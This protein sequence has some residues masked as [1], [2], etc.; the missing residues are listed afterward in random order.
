MNERRSQRKRERGTIVSIIEMPRCIPL[1][2]GGGGERTALTVVK[3]FRAAGVTVDVNM[4][5]GNGRARQTL[6]RKEGRKED[7]HDTI[8]GS[9]RGKGGGKRTQEGT[10]GVDNEQL[11]E[12]ARVVGRD[13]RACAR[14]VIRPRDRARSR[15]TRSIDRFLDSTGRVH[16]SLENFVAR[17]R[18][19]SGNRRDTRR[20]FHIFQVTRQKGSSCRLTRDAIFKLRHSFNYSSNL[21]STGL[22]RSCN[23]RA[24]Y[25]FDA[26]HSNA[27]ECQ[28]SECYLYIFPQFVSHFSSFKRKPAKVYYSKFCP[29]KEISR[30]NYYA[31]ACKQEKGITK[32]I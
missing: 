17:K 2:G 24:S 11:T 14:A 25:A 5:T 20:E 26:P 22:G 9:A 6:R 10:G 19:G 3:P 31:N 1:G 4:V 29:A 15:V 12:R 21:F 8:E 13:D 30:L 7:A 18:P 23:T 16:R 32:K 27:I 28:F